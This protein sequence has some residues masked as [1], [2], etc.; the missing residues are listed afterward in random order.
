MDSAKSAD[1]RSSCDVSRWVPLRFVAEPIKVAYETSPL[2]EKDPECPD[3]FVWRKHTYQVVEQISAWRDYERR[4][5]MARNMT[6]GHLATASR[7]GSWGVG[8]LYFRVRT[9]TGQ[10]FDMYYDRRPRSVE[11]RKGQWFLYRELQ[12]S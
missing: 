9:D 3:Q 2:L 12:E 8:R 10:V 7:R 6:P 5:L 4:G 11:R 1:V